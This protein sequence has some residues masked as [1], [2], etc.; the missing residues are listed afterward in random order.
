MDEKDK[1]GR[2]QVIIGILGLIVT[3]CSVIIGYIPHTTPSSFY[4]NPSQYITS[5]TTGVCYY[6]WKGDFE[7]KIGS[8][9]A[10]LGYTF[11]NVTVY[12]KNEAEKEVGGY[13]WKLNADG[14]V[15]EYYAP[16]SYSMNPQQTRIGKG[17]EIEWKLVY[18]VK[19]TPAQKELVYGGVYPEMKRIKH[20]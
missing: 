9:T 12:M 6:D 4:S 13:G 19:G 7:S 3:V 17:G 1:W 2:L 11:F 18:L 16:I 8:E 20:Y 14:L 5:M 15:Y 10:P